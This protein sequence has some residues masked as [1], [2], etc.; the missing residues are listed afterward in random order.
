MKEAHIIYISVKTATNDQFGGSL[1][2]CS[3]SKF[4][5]FRV[6]ICILYFHPILDFYLN[7]GTLVGEFNQVHSQGF[8]VLYEHVLITTCS[9]MYACCRSYLIITLLYR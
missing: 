9:T 2:N 1:D 7:F 4:K 8:I 5:V 6:Q 3:I